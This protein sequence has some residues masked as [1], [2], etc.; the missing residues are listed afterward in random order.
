MLVRENAPDDDDMS[1][2]EDYHKD[3][4]EDD[5]IA[6]NEDDNEIDR[7]NDE[8]EEDDGDLM[9]DEAAGK[10]YDI[11]D[12]PDAE[13]DAVVQKDTTTTSIAPG[14]AGNHAPSAAAAAATTVSRQREPSYSAA[15]SMS[16]YWL[17]A[18]MEKIWQL[19][20]VNSNSNSNSTLQGAAQRKRPRRAVVTD[21]EK[22]K[23]LLQPHELQRF[24]QARSPPQSLFPI[25]RLLLSEKDSSRSFNLKENLLA[26]A[27]V[28][29]FQLIHDDAR[30]IVCFTDPMAVG[31]DRAGDLSRVIEAVLETRIAHRSGSRLTVGDINQWLDEF[32]SLPAQAQAARRGE[33]GSAGTTIH[34][35][36]TIH[37]WR[38]T[39]PSPARQKRRKGPSL[40]E[41][42]AE[43]IRRLNPPY[44]PTKGELSP[45]EHKWL[46][47]IMLGKLQLGLG[48]MRIFNWYHPSA[49]AIWSS[50]NSLKG[51][52]NILCHPDFIVMRNNHRMQEDGGANDQEPRRGTAAA[53]LPR[54]KDPVQFGVPFEPMLS[55]RTSFQRALTNLSSRHRD[56]VASSSTLPHV[57]SSWLALRHPVF[58]VET[59]LDGE[60][61]LIHFSRDGV[62]KIHSRRGKWHR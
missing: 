18:R 9:M 41:L 1:D 4:G 36:S 34:A 31:S 43:W 14:A 54:N 37:D 61:M 60:R 7:R 15:N 21:E 48:W 55:E 5:N 13:D 17:C 28:D 35:T 12:E 38:T 32:V 20:L 49:T 39:T 25:L 42:R 57:D 24:E 47:R 3:D 44:S 58:S 23:C 50:H 19:K 11:D 53:Y 62:I 2:N 8:D 51:V 56:F 22:L 33:T 59:K 6:Y 16:F 52:C 26:K 46:I 29:A 45:M 30:K 40:K 27:Y 10:E